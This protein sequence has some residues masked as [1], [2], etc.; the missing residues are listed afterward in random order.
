MADVR[1]C[2]RERSVANQDQIEFY[3]EANQLIQGP[4][5]VTVTR[6][7]EAVCVL[8][9]EQDRRDPVCV[10]VTLIGPWMSWLASE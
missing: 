2:I 6:T 7:I 3:S 10:T 1:L 4:I 5:K 8:F 9:P